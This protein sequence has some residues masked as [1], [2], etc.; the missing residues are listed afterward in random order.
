MKKTLT[1]FL[2]SILVLSNTNLFSQN[3]PV[4][5][6]AKITLKGQGIVDT[7][8]DNMAYWIKMAKLGYVETEPFRNIP[9]AVFTGS[10][11]R[12]NRDMS[13]TIDSPDVP[14]TG[15]SSTQSE[16]STFIKPTDN[17]SLMNSNNSTS[18]PVNSVYG[19]DYLLSSDG[20]E[21]WGGSEN[22]AGGTNSGDPALAISL[23]GRYYVGFINN[24]SGQS[25]AYSTNSGTS[26][27]VKVVASVS[28]PANDLLD[29]NHLWIDNVSTSAYSGYLYDAWTTFASGTAT[30]QITLKYS[31]NGGV[32]WSAQKILSANINAGSH[33]QGVNLQTGPNGEVYA[34]WA[35]YDSWPSDEAALGFAKST[36]GGSTFAAST[37]I[38]SNIRGIRNTG[39]NKD[40]RVNSFPSMAVDISGGT[41]SGNIYVVWCNV[42]S[43]GIN[44]G[45]DEDIYMIRSTNSGA[46]FS[47]PVKVNQDPSGLGK[48]HYQ[49]WISCD[50]V[51]GDLF[52]IYYDDRN[53]GSTE[54]EVYVSCSYDGGD[55]WEDIKVS[56]VAFTPAPIPNLADSYMG[57]YLGIAARGKRVYP[58]WSDNRTGSAMTYSSPFDV[59]YTRFSASNVHPCQDETVTLT[60]ES[61]KGPV[62][63]NWTITP[64]T[65]SF[66]NGTSAT[67]QNPQIQFNSEDTYTVSL[68]TVNS[69]SS[70]TLTRIN[71]ISVALGQPDFNANLTTVNTG[72]NVVF[73]DASACTINSYYWDFGSGA[74][75]PYAFGSG[76]Y[77]VYY[78]IPGEKNVSLTVNG[79]TSESKSNYINVTTTACHNIQIVIETDDYPEET[80]W[81]LTDNSNN[82]VVASGG[83]Y[84][85]TGPQDPVIVCCSETKCYTFTIYDAY[86]DGICCSYGDGS[87]TLTDLTSS[88]VLGTGGVIR[89]NGTA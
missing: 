63:W 12:I 84:L 24:N 11:I 23:N 69:I 19:A 22:G 52:V 43:P 80:T 27:T 29:K 87:Y 78:E 89:I 79:T 53:V 81:Q 55:T 73:T 59:N 46:S 40:M 5:R 20:G 10:K 9:P 72:D 34:V 13:L 15:N 39:T 54:C 44:T 61:V 16:N 8:V 42:G 47:A 14:V 82:Q 64:T 88:T 33:N 75:P 67:A 1:S 66:V 7:R 35:V 6:F 77:S 49:P 76:P 83:P 18:N 85:T 65:F 37:R 48:E 31:S 2:L 62:S 3:N 68:V 30:N 71:Y 25:L 38:I 74:I 17:Q 51:S 86:G 45:N 32:S 60:D 28:D 50:P 57:D 58:T 26:W 41:N 21:S 36:N 56:D 4:D 70:D